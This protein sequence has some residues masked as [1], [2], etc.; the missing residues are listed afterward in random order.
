MKGILIVGMFVADRVIMN[1]IMIVSEQI[2]IIIMG[3]F[4]DN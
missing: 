1:R 3:K 4:E 2:I